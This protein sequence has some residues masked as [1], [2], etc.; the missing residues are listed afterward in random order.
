MPSASSSRRVL[1]LGLADMQLQ[2]RKALA[3]HR[4]DRRQKVGRDRRNDAQTQAARQQPRMVARVLAE[5]ANLGQN[6]RRALSD[7]P[8]GRGELHALVS[9]LDQLDAEFPFQILNLRRQ[10]RLGDG[11]VPC[12]EAEMPEPGQGVQI[13]KLSHC[14]H[15]D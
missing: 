13:A 7:L 6:A 1:R 2:F 14:R 15:S 10:R 3:D 8:A 11:A 5:I 9:A 4:Q 12:R